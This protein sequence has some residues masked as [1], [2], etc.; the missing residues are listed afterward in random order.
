M[1]ETKFEEWFQWAP[2]RPPAPLPFHGGTPMLDP[3]P[4]LRI[5]RLFAYFIPDFVVVD[6]LLSLNSRCSSSQKSTCRRRLSNSCSPTALHSS[7][8]RFRGSTGSEIY[9]SSRQISVQLVSPTYV[10]TISLWSLRSW[11]FKMHLAL[12]YWPY[13]VVYLRDQ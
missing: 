1:F 11:S 6:T 4:T 13:L 2:R 10:G 7:T 12:R 5:V 3:L 9:A 8:C